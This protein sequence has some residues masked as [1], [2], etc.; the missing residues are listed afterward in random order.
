MKKN[1]K[2]IAIWLFCVATVIMV[3]AVGIKIGQQKQFEKTYSAIITSLGEAEV[4][5]T[6][7]KDIVAAKSKFIKV[8]KSLDNAKKIEFKSVTYINVADFIERLDGLSNGKLEEVIYSYNLPVAVK[9]SAKD[10]LTARKNTATLEKALLFVDLKTQQKEIIAFKP[11]IIKTLAEL[12]IYGNVDLKSIKVLNLLVA[13]YGSILNDYSKKLTTF[14]AT[15]NRKNITINKVNEFNVDIL[16]NFA[17]FTFALSLT[18][19]LLKIII[20]L[21]SFFKK[22]FAKDTTM[23]LLEDKRIIYAEKPAQLIQEKAKKIVLTKRRGK[24]IN[25]FTLK[26]Y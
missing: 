8:L 21:K 4:N 20:V 26:P 11:I 3:V 24:G 9:N 10:F 23:L 17:L 18:L 2:K 6:A 15:V 13:D 1:L 22:L 16:I 25:I 5:L 12:K 7:P 14:E 19:F